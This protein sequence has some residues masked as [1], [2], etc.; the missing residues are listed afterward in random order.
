VLARFEDNVGQN[1]LSSGINALDNCY[2]LL[3]A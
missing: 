1:R 2:L 3:V